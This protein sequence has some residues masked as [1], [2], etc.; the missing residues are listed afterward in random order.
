MNQ[1]T[2]QLF[3]PLATIALAFSFA[4]IICM[5]WLVGEPSLPAWTIPLAAISGA[6]AVTIILWRQFQA[7][8][9][10]IQV[11]QTDWQNRS[12]A[13]AQASQQQITRLEEAQKA[14]K[15]QVHALLN[16]VEMAASGGDN[17]TQL[18]QKLTADLVAHQYA[19]AFEIW[20]IQADA[21]NLLSGKTARNYE[22]LS[23]NAP[24]AFW[25]WLAQQPEGWQ[26][27]SAAA[28]FPEQAQGFQASFILPHQIANGQ[29]TAWQSDTGEKGFFLLENIDNEQVANAYCQVANQI[30]DRYFIEQKVCQQN[31]K[32]SAQ[33]VQIAATAEQLRHKEATLQQLQ[34]LI[35]ELRAQIS[36]QNN[37]YELLLAEHHLIYEGAPGGLAYF[38]A[39]EPIGLF[40]ETDAQVRLL[41]QYLKL[42][43]C[44]R[45]FA[46]RNGQEQPQQ[47]IGTRFETLFPN[48]NG[49]DTV[50]ILGQMLKDGH[51]AEETLEQ[52]RDGNLYRCY[53]QYRA[54]KAENHLLGVLVAHLRFAKLHPDVSQAALHERQ[55]RAWVTRQPVFSLLA[56]ASGSIKELTLALELFTGLQK[57]QH[58][59]GILH[60]EDLAEVQQ[61]YYF[62][63]AAAPDTLNTFVARF[64]NKE[65]QWREG[66]FVLYNAKDEAIGGGIIV[67]I[68]DVT[69]YNQRHRTE[70]ARIELLTATLDS[71]ADPV[72][73]MDVKNTFLYANPAM[74]A[75]AG[76][77]RLATETLAQPPEIA[78][79]L[80][81]K[82]GNTEIRWRN[83]A[84]QQT[85][86]METQVVRL[87]ANGGGAHTVIHLHDVTRSR[88]Q[89]ER[90]QLQVDKFS[91][92][93]MQSAA[94][95]ALCAPDGDIRW[96]NTAF[97]QALGFTDREKI[98]LLQLADSESDTNPMALLEEVILQP[99]LTL[100]A[101]FSYI[102]AKGKKCWGEWSFLNL[103]RHE[104]IG[105]ILI[106]LH[107]C[108]SAKI[109]VEK[110]ARHHRYTRALLSN[111]RHAAILTDKEGHALLWTDTA[112]FLQL[113][114][115]Q[116]IHRLHDTDFWETENG[117]TFRHRHSFAGEY[118]VIDV[119]NITPLV[120]LRDALEESIAAEKAQVQYTCD[121]IARFEAIIADMQTRMN[122][123]QHTTDLAVQTA[124]TGTQA[125][126]EARALLPDIVA[127]IQLLPTLQHYMQ[128]WTALLERY[129]E[130]GET[131]DISA[132]L[133][134]I[135]A[136]R[137]VVEGDK[138]P[139]KTQQLISTFAEKLQAIHQA[140]SYLQRLE[141]ALK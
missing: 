28:A 100:S 81:Y 133:L 41:H 140:V 117:H 121:V 51:F 132:K 75:L 37:D 76:N 102:N 14:L 34:Q 103:L 35:G 85:Q 88:E 29:L 57:G 127:A 21:V 83:Q 97:R 129:E 125:I 43:S 96:A 116:R 89:A 134:E 67:A 120:E 115:G 66:D 69:E 16:A 82:G 3:S 78:A 94:A 141:P 99:E 137:I 84:L 31:E 118:A 87:S 10:S 27:H 39:E 33:A 30:L 79:Q 58:L 5:L 62:T 112:N 38:T 123:L 46:R 105:A 114:T 19:N 45:Q 95:I 71:I 26:W 60:P 2:P 53:K 6:L 50:A 15:K 131:T 80:L 70:R 24:Q 4:L 36:T 68:H 126:A 124:I 55:L 8:N 101:A 98:D 48:P 25:E 49:R 64:R 56:D 91:G 1:P 9:N 59:F 93:A 109:Q 22:K 40:Y 107:E 44:N 20:Q 23:L 108:T 128:D 13:A 32:I 90:L 61:K 113:R 92:I 138:L 139:E 77:G 65:N 7:I 11:Q 18:L 42:K 17:L 47:M 104:A 63:A 52:D 86:R 12:L 119:E 136:F 74:K 122:T 73:A 110:L 72:A 135:S 106:T 111:T 54:I 130:I